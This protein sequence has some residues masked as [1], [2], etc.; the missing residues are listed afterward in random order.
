MVGKVSSYSQAKHIFLC[1]VVEGN[2]TLINNIKKNL[3]TLTQKYGIFE[4]L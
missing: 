3:T 2:E 1:A 4:S